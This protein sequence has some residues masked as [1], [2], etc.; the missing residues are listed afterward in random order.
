MLRGA[1]VAVVVV[2]M[3]VSALVAKG[4]RST[5][6]RQHDE[7]L[8]RGRRLADGDDRGHD[9]QLR[10]RPPGRSL[11][12]SSDSVSRREFNAF[13]RSIDLRERSRAPGHRLALVRH[14]RSAGR[15]RPGSSGRGAGR[16]AGAVRLRRPGLRAPL[17]P[18]PGS[19][20]LTDRTIPA[21][22][23][24]VVWVALSVLFG[25]MPWLLAQVGALYREV[26]RLA[27]TDSL[28]DR[29]LYAAK[30]AGRDRI[31]ADGPTTVEAAAP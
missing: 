22:V 17:R 31:H 14:R 4:W 19:P 1:A 29:A 15:G 7:R 10:E 13:A 27:R 8:D 23:M 6:V 11:W 20:I 26:G 9:G 3:V 18:L 25:A 24:L 21:P 2:G 5:I 28:T 12:V 16:A 30:D